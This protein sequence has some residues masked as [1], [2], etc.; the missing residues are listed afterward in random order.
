MMLNKLSC[1]PK[2]LGQQFLPFP[3][4]HGHPGAAAPSQ[5]GRA[6]ARG[7]GSQEG[8]CPALGRTPLEGGACQRVTGAGDGLC[9]F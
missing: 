6:L 1:L 9:V 5:K 8:G 7:A 3:S 4:L 2:V